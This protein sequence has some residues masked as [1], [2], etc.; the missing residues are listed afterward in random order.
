MD[1]DGYVT[2][3]GRIKDRIRRCGENISA[4]DIE[5]CL[6]ALPGVDQIAAFAVPSD[7]WGGEDEIMCAVLAVVGPEIEP[8]AIVAH[9]AARMPRYAR[10]RYVEFVAAL[11]R[12]A[13]EM[14]RKTD[15]RVCGI[16]AQTLDLADL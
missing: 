10:P 11:P 1:A 2:V 13:P 5:A 16:T 3:V 8:A 4:T 12:T 15:L 6:A 14:V 9:A 7:I